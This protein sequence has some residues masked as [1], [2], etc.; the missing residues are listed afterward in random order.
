V[1]ARTAADLESLAA[2]IQAQGRRCLP[3]PADVTDP[4]QV[5]ALAAQVQREWGAL[6]ILVNNAG[7]ARSHKFR[8]HPD[9]L[10]HEMLAANLT[11]VYYVSKACLPLLIAT[12]GGRIVNIASTAARIGER[13][14][15]AYT[16]AKHGVLGLVRAAAAE[17]ARTGVTV[18]AVCPGY[19]DTDIVRDSIR[20]VAAKTGRAQAEVLAEYERHAP[21]GRLIRP[22]EVA[23]AVL[24]L[25]SPEAAAVTGTTLAIAGGEM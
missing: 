23:A 5:Q 25:C 4:A 21:I 18:N 6:D 14:V 12:G 1:T 19:T 20:R 15:A 7:T 10:W 8:D 17:V 22:E 9:A 2:E 16:A 24:Y 3:L 11:S 13:Y